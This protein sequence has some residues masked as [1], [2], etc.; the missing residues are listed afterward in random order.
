M[1]LVEMNTEMKSRLNYL[2]D[3]EEVARMLCVSTKTLEYWRWKKVGPKYI[4]IGRLARYR[5]ADVVDYVLGL[6]EQAAAK[7]V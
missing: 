7:F 1:E 2:L 6:I 5:E 3:Q 4:K